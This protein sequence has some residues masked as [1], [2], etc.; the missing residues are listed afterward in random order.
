MDSKEK[1][2]YGIS[3]EG[4]VVQVE[5]SLTSDENI[6]L[7]ALNSFEYRKT[8]RKGRDLGTVPV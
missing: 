2:Y 8:L 3:D 5:A 4:F 1:Q 6:K 7:S